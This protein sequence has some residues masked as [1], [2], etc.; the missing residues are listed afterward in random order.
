[1]ELFSNYLEECKKEMLD[2]LLGIIKN[3]EIKFLFDV[4]VVKFFKELKEIVF[5]VSIDLVLV[6]GN[7]VEEE[8]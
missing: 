4:A 7:F 5:V 3:K 8:E 1:M 2:C 6:D